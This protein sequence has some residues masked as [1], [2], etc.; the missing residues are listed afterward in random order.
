MVEDPVDNVADMALQ[1]YCIPIPFRQCGA[2]DHY[3]TC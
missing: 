2:F 1:N 3:T